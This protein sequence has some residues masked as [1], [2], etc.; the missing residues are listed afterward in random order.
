M[1]ISLIELL[2]GVVGQSSTCEYKG[3]NSYKIWC[4]AAE[5]HPEYEKAICEYLTE[6]RKRTDLD[7]IA[8]KIEEIE[9]SLSAA[10]SMVLEFKKKHGIDDGQ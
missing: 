4:M 8:S 10:R 3:I 7:K 9:K 2:M 1:E 6:K 5:K